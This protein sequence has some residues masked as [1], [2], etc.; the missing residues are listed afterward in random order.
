M[1]RVRAHSL[2][3]PEHAFYIGD[4]ARA[5]YGLPIDDAARAA[6]AALD[7][8]VLAPHRGLRRPGISAAQ[9]RPELAHSVTID[10]IRVASPATLWAMSARGLDVRGLVR[11]GDAI[12]RVPRGERGRRHPDQQLATPAQLR[13][14][15][16]A[17]RRRGR[18]K[19]RAA[20]PLVR[21]GSMSVLETDWRLNL[22]NS[23]LPEPDLDVE[24]RDGGGA[25]LGISD[26]AFPAYRL[27]VEVE[28]DGHRT[29][30]RQWHRDIEKYAAYA[31]LGWETIRLTSAHIRGP[32][33]HDVRLVR[34]GLTRHGW[35]P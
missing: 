6:T 15:I 33:G 16:E 17:G 30:R 34:E 10:G 12:V 5:V 32:G 25:L 23:G 4:A 11:L 14:S 2:V 3:L 18:E 9:V 21:I 35:T 31:A 29:S 20:L 26:G 24:V 13:A 1:S 7:V 27:V 28:G 22:L 8:A 19:L